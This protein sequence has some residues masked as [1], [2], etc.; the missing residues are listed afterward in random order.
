MLDSLGVLE[1]FPIKIGKFTFLRVLLEIFMIQ[2]FYSIKR[3]QFDKR[4]VLIADFALIAL[5]V[6][7]FKKVVRPNWLDPLPPLSKCVRNR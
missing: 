5:S 4:K 6:L 3:W 2:K 7:G 1:G